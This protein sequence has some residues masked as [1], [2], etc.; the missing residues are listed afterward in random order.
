MI[1][2]REIRVT[3]VCVSEVR[4]VLVTLASALDGCALGEEQPELD[5]FFLPCNGSKPINIVLERDH[6]M[7]RSQTDKSKLGL[8]F[9]LELVPS[10]GTWMNLW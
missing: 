4:S 3:A 7:T 5:F 9:V 10:R 2:H 1:Q 6:G 8:M